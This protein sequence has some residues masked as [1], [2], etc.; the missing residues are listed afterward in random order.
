MSKG[1]EKG[2]RRYVSGHLLPAFEADVL[3]LLLRAGRPL[4]VA[5]VQASLPGPSRAYTTVATI[6]GRLVE[7]GLV[8]GERSGRLYRYRPVGDERRLAELA[9]D[10]LLESVSDPEAVIL[11][12]L[13][14]KGKR[15]EER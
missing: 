5:E 15:G 13:R 14:R 7:R 1:R 12:F 3:E 8:V 9:L 4:S 10:R 2:S 6:I 11:G